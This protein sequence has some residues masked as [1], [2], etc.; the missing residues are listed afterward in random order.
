MEEYN[1]CLAIICKF[2]SG[3]LGECSKKTTP[4]SEECMLIRT[5]IPDEVRPLPRDE[6]R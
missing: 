6:D 2:N 5:D 4:S 1:V 3:V